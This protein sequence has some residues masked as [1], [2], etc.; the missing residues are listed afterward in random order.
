MYGLYVGV[1]LKQYH[2]DFAFLIHWIIKL[3]SKQGL[4][5]RENWWQ[6]I[7]NQWG[8]F[9]LLDEKNPD[10]NEDKMKENIYLENCEL[11]WYEINDSWKKQLKNS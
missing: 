7:K 8:K 10:G 4:I 6:L 2:K 5:I 1:L 9:L 3:F 11:Q